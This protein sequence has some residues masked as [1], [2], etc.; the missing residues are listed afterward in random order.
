M[1]EQE[2]TGATHTW[3]YRPRH[4]GGTLL[5][6]VPVVHVAARAG[7]EPPVIGFG[8]LAG[9]GLLVVISRFERTL[10]PFA[11]GILLT[12]MSVFL[13][14]SLDGAGVERATIFLGLFGVVLVVSETSP[15]RHISR[16]INERIDPYVEAAGTRLGRWLAPLLSRLS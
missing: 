9:G 11:A 12:G 6:A 3:P 5:A 16:R 2:V 13:Q 14:A 8:M 10:R 1:V 4:V 15:V 7:V